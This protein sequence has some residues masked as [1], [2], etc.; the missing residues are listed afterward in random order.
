MADAINTGTMLIEQDAPLPDSLG[1]ESEPWTLFYRVGEIIRELRKAL[2]NRAG[3]G[4][5]ETSGDGPKAPARPEDHHRDEEPSSRMGDKG[6]PN[7]HHAAT[8]P[9]A[10]GSSGIGGRLLLVGSPIF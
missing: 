3:T 4:A 6:C 9:D 5:K 8:V 7:H 10:T 2:E 1:F